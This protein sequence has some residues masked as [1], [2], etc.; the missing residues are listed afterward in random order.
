[1]PIALKWRWQE[2]QAVMR[3]DGK[4]ENPQRF[5]MDRPDLAS[6]VRVLRVGGEEGEKPTGFRC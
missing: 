5:W 2:M 3:R 1:M 4:T 6:N